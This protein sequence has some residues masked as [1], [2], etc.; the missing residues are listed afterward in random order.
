MSI[1]KRIKEIIMLGS[2]LLLVSCSGGNEN[3]TNPIE[4]G[5]SYIAGA[6]LTHA[7]LNLIKG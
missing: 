3:A 2:F 6:I 1:G 7:L 5:C 4:R